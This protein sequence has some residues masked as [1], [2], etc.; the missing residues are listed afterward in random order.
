MQVV[1][2]ASFMKSCE[3]GPSSNEGR[4]SVCPYFFLLFMNHDITHNNCG[5]VIIAGNL[6]RPVSPIFC[7]IFEQAHYFPLQNSLFLIVIFG[8]CNIHGIFCYQGGIW[9]V[10]NL[11]T[12][13]PGT[14]SNTVPWVHQTPVKLYFSFRATNEF[15][16]TLTPLPQCSICYSNYFSLQKSTS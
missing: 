5:I 1:V 10:V 11:G 7:L 15:P 8:S 12:N 4:V 3:S 9:L 14:P 2:L 6:P 13:L 16:E